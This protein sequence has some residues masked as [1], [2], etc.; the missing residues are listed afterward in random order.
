MSH[1]TA[2]SCPSCSGS[3]SRVKLY[4][5]KTKGNGISDGYYVCPVTAEAVHYFAAID[6]DCT[7]RTAY[8]SFCKM[9][10]KRRWLMLISV[11]HCDDDVNVEHDVE[12][13][14]T[15]HDFPK[16]DIGKV[17]EFVKEHIAPIF[18]TMTMQKLPFADLTIHDPLEHL[19]EERD[20]GNPASD[21]AP[22]LS[23]E[24]PEAKGN[25]P[26]LSNSDGRNSGSQSLSD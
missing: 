17:L 7:R 3:H 2:E 9:M 1:I 23:V 8:S 22:V 19:N 14:R 25:E 5:P 10:K 18:P 16:S 4:R 15:T 12:S 11:A 6:G 26:S 24:S 20:E 21:M 13:F